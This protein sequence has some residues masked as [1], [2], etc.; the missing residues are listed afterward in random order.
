LRRARK[1]SYPYWLR[2]G[3]WGVGRFVGAGN[4][5]LRSR[6]IGDYYRVKHTRIYEKDLRSVFPEVPEWPANYDLFRY[7]GTELD[8]TAQWL[9]WNE[10]VGHLTMVLL[11]VDRASMHHSLEVRVPLLDR[12]VID[13]ASR[14]D[15]RSCMD[16]KQ[17]VGKFPLRQSLSRHV[18]FQARAKRGF[19]APMNAWLRGPLKDT[20][21]EVVM[22]RKELLGMP[23]NQKKIGAMFQ[24]H[25]EKRADQTRSLWTLLSLA[26]W[27]KKHY[28]ARREANNSA[29]LKSSI[30]ARRT[31]S[32]PKGLVA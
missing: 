32:E 28:Q 5:D 12:E 21:H 14:V 10:F 13:V 8:R 27:E 17:N 4:P 19:E 18:H 16:L 30:L 1:F 23:L 2:F 25:M 3:L 11:K 15:W 31:L 20:F 22:T 29:T 6:N 7:S 9:R 24:Q 26:L